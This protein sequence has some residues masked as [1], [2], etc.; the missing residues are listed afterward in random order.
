MPDLS[1]RQNLEERPDD[2][3]AVVDALVKIAI[4]GFRSKETETK[5]LEL[6]ARDIL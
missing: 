3:R 4:A 6:V 1:L 2:L 5:T